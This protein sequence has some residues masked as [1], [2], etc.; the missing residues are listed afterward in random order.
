MERKRVARVLLCHYFAYPDGVKF[1]TYCPVPDVD[2]IS[3]LSVYPSAS[4]F[5]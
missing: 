1:R 3:I 2:S 4:R 5:F